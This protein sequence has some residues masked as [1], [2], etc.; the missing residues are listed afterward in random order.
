MNDQ[1]VMDLSLKN[2]LNMNLQKIYKGRFGLLTLF[3]SIFFSSLIHY[4]NSTSH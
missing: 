4:K 3:F 2:G 1:I